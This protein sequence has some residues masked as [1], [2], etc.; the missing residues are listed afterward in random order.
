MEIDGPIDLACCKT[1]RQ[2]ERIAMLNQCGGNVYQA[3]ER[4]NIHPQ[5]I[6]DILHRFRLQGLI[7]KRPSC[8]LEKALRHGVFRLGGL[9][10][11]MRRQDRAVRAWVAANTPEGG[12]VA[13][14][15]WS[16]FADLTEEDG[17]NE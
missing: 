9:N 7:E 10:A 6:Y 4:L 2:R 12:T 15:A 8:P 5:Q 17:Y 13:D 14:L 1:A 16:V 3:A 11:T